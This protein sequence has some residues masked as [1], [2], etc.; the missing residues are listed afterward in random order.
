MASGPRIDPRVSSTNTASLADPPSGKRAKQRRNHTG[1]RA[2][3]IT[4][5]ARKR[6]RF[7]ALK[8]P[9]SVSLWRMPST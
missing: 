4:R 1:I 6:S 7:S 9:A 5:M 3:V 8:F 2:M